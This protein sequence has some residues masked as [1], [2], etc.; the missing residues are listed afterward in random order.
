MTV[1]AIQ[2]GL[3]PAVVDYGSP[4]F[5][6]F[7]GLSREKLQAANDDN[8]AALRDAGYDV[9]GCPVDL[10]ELAVNVVREAITRKKYDAVLI[11]AGIRLISSNTELFEAIVN[12][13]HT[14]LP[15]CRFVFNKDAES[16]PDDI[17]RWYPDPMA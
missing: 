16:T 6:R 13:V 1:S 10:G 14:E 12:V 5:A 8:I 15:D 2:I 11:G 7:E 4:E 17:R 3:D 9:D